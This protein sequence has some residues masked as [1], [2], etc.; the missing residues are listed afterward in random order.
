MT[1][2]AMDETLGWCDTLLN[3]I[4]QS[5]DGDDNRGD[6]SDELEDFNDRLTGWRVWVCLADDEGRS[7]CSGEQHELDKLKR[8][9]ELGR[10][11]VVTVVQNEA[12]SGNTKCSMEGPLNALLETEERI[13]SLT[14]SVIGKVPALPPGWTVDDLLA[15]YPRDTLP[16]RPES[17]ADA[18]TGLM[19]WIDDLVEAFRQALEPQ[20]RPPTH[21]L[22]AENARLEVR[23]MCHQLWHWRADVK[24]A[25]ESGRRLWLDESIYSVMKDLFAGAHVELTALIQDVRSPLQFHR[26]PLDC[27]SSTIDSITGTGRAIVYE[28]PD[29]SLLSDEEVRLMGAE[30]GSDEAGSAGICLPARQERYGSLHVPTGSH[31]TSERDGNLQ[32]TYTHSTV[33]F[34]RKNS[35]DDMASE[36]IYWLTKTS[37]TYAAEFTILKTL[38]NKELLDRS[39]QAMKPLL[40]GRSRYK[41]LRSRGCQT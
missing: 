20:E 34:V 13:F 2:R 23:A 24:R 4:K 29:L 38:E 19:T 25:Y 14:E 28:G 22:A 10:Q 35:H 8:L 31:A 37:V 18:Y 3:A 5:R 33:R 27:L 9:F 17:D 7:L 11:Q 12:V 21:Q 41:T 6:L 30:S 16:C 26:G 15:P 1:A 40:T 36:H 32:N 39:Q